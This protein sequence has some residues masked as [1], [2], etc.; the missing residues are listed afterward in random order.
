VYGFHASTLKC[1]LHGEQVPIK[2][3]F[4][5]GCK[6]EEREIIGIYDRE[7]RRS[8]LKARELENAEQMTATG[9]VN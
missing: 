5:D 9:T 6:G 3:T 1:K 8:Q 4:R 2:G 7:K